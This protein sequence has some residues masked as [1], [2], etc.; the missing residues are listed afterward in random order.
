MRFLCEFPQIFFGEVRSDF[1]DIVETELNVDLSSV[2]GVKLQSVSVDIPSVLDFMAVWHEILEV[3]SLEID[4][5]T[6]LGNISNAFHLFA[7][8]ISKNVGS[9]LS[10]G[11]FCLGEINDLL[12][13]YNE[14][15]VRNLSDLT[16]V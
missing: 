7:Y 16:G 12:L 1:V 10:I 8:Q 15:I 3:F 5:L 4:T 13:L 11:S 2:E 9:L 14:Q 6:Q